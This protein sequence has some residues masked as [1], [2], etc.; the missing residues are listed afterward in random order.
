MKKRCSETQNKITVK[1]CCSN[2]TKA[3]SW[4][5][6]SRLWHPKTWR[7]V[8][9]LHHH[10]QN[11]E[12]KNFARVKGAKKIWRK[13][14]EDFPVVLCHGDFT[15]V[16]Y[17]KLSLGGM[18]LRFLEMSFLLTVDMHAWHRNDYSS[19]RHTCKSHEI[20]AIAR[21]LW[22]SL[23]TPSYLSWQASKSFGRSCLHCSVVR[24]R[25][26]PGAQN[27]PLTRQVV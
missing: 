23:G 12:P 6:S 5:G 9:S 10:L 3:S 20:S 18:K 25:G 7:P 19:F 13:L 17:G 11:Q 24:R 1:G 16:V 26:V 8:E 21:S 14:W 22:G 15:R 4:H 2:V 27:T